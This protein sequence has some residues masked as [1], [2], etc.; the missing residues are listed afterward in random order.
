[1]SVI[2]RFGLERDPWLSAV[3]ARFAWRVT[4]EP[5]GTPLAELR[6]SG[7]QFATAKLSAADTS[8]V[9]ALESFGFRVV[10]TAL[11]FDADAVVSV[12]P[13][14]RVRFAR[15][16]DAHEVE[17]VAGAAFRFSR[18]HLD[19]AI[20]VDLAHRMKAEWAANWF[21][22]T[23]GDGMIVAEDAGRVAGFLQLLWSRDGRLVI[24]LIGVAAGSRARGLARAMIGL[25]ARQ[26]TGDSRRPNGLR[27][28]T[29]AANVPSVRLY[30]SLGFR[31][32]DSQYVLHFHG[33]AAQ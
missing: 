22:G 25:A 24:D 8:S 19:R 14:S 7:L 2:D 29:Q 23:R 4:M 5:S 1:M 15:A 32:S 21:R 9:N 17:A 11:S 10:D 18:F 6:A 30:E 27:V 31:L 3:L 26:G 13:D 33:G 12:D 20:P 28:G 16:D